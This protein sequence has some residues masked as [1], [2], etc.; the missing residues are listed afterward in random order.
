ME[1]IPLSF[2]VWEYQNEQEFLLPPRAF[3]RPH[4]PVVNSPHGPPQHK[5]ALFTRE[6]TFCE[7]ETPFR[8][9]TQN[10]SFSCS[11]VCLPPRCFAS[12]SN[13]ALPLS[14]HPHI[15]PPLS[16]DAW[17]RAIEHCLSAFAGFSDFPEVPLIWKLND[18]TQCQNSWGTIS[19]LAVSTLSAFFSLFLRA[20]HCRKTQAQSD[21][22]CTLLLSI[23]EF[24][25]STCT[26]G[27]FSKNPQ[28][29]NFD[30]LQLCL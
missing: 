18:S 8:Y 22:Y 24:D 28:G 30:K 12:F 20:T 3:R 11:S 9:E 29:A 15:H 21:D 4:F 23:I 26:K 27:T 5:K 10:A 19:E 25:M 6:T 2:C 17:L 1:N 14:R 7:D 16:S 13:H